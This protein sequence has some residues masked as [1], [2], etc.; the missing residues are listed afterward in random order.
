MALT[1]FFIIGT[2]SPR[3]LYEADG[4][5][6]NPRDTEPAVGKWY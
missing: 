1:G 4:L 2:T 3:D 5:T 6:R